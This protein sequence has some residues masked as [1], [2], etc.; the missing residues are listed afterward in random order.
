MAPK[1]LCFLKCD[2]AHNYLPAS[3]TTVN[4]Q[5]VINYVDNIFL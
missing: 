5:C 2:K 4:R 1:G 3:L